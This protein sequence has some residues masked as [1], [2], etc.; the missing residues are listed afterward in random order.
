VPSRGRGTVPQEENRP[1]AG[2]VVSR[3]ERTRIRRNRLVPR[4]A[5]VIDESCHERGRSID[6]R[7]VTECG[8]VDGRYWTGRAD[9]EWTEL[10]AVAWSRLTV[11]RRVASRVMHDQPTRRRTRIGHTYVRDHHSTRVSSIR[12]DLVC[13]SPHL[14]S[15]VARCLPLVDLCSA[16][17]ATSDGTVNSTSAGHD[18]AVQQA[19]THK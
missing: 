2:S 13:S 18:A 12:F 5:S 7:P 1:I 16:E 11:R 15:R 8:K 17:C 3:L 10:S 9:R 19:R 6:H 14:T 4:I